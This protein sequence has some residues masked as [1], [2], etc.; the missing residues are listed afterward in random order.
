M[1]LHCQYLA[2]VYVYHNS[3]RNEIYVRLQHWYSLISEN[4]V[5]NNTIVNSKLG[6]DIEDIGPLLLIYS[7]TIINATENAIDIE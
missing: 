3:H 1:R 4:S 6:I 7:N 5:Y 2:N